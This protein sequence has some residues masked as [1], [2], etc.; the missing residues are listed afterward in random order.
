MADISKECQESI[1][2][3]NLL[4]NKAV[5]EIKVANARAEA[6]EKMLEV[7]KNSTS[8]EIKKAYLIGYK[9]GVES[10]TGGGTSKTNNNPK[11][12]LK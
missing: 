11:L 5:K 7:L 9:K 12:V 3:I 1:I 2:N 8:D 4:I 10:V 6:A